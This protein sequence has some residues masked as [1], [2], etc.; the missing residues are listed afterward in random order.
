MPFGLTVSDP[1]NAMIEA[2]YRIAQRMFQMLSLSERYYPRLGLE[3]TDMRA[4]THRYGGLGGKREEGE[5]VGNNTGPSRPCLC[6]S[7]H[8][9]CELRSHQCI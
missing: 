6:A 7:E 1:K 4:R 3:P 8:I 5:G 2:S 9:L